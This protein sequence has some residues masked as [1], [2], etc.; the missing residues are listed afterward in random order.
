M[1]KFVTPTRVWINAPSTHSIYNKFHGKVGIAHTHTNSL[2]N[3]FTTLYFTEGEMSSMTID[4]FYLESKNSQND[5][6]RINVKYYETF[7]STKSGFDLYYYNTITNEF[8][9]SKG[10]FETLELAEGKAER[11]GYQHKPMYWR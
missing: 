8:D 4:P 3:E 2:G 5:N 11:E 10:N 6:L 7:A 9:I 1:K